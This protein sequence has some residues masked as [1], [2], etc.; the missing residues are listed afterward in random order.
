LSQDII[1]AHL[2]PSLAALQR[3][4]QDEAL[5]GVARKI[6]AAIIAAPVVQQIHLAVVHGICD[7]I[8]RTMMRE[9]LE[10]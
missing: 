2:Q 4:T 7:E 3:A 8:E 5:P 1:G 9:T 10:K 6:A